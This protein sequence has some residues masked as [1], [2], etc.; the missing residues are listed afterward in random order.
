MKHSCPEKIR[1]TPLNRKRFNPSEINKD[2]T[3][4]AGQAKEYENSI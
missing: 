2:F 1:D 4:Q 3:G